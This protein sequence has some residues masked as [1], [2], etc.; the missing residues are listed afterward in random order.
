[1]ARPASYLS[2][3]TQ[4]FTQS[5][6]DVANV[7]DLPRDRAPSRCAYEGFQ[8]NKADHAATPAAPKPHDSGKITGQPDKNGKPYP[9]LLPRAE[10]EAII[11]EQLG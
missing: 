7:D 6:W 9:C 2:D 1:M 4:T 3:I 10:L 11:A 8:L 5:R